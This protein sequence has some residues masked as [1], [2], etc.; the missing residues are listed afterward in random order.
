MQVIA[1]DPADATQL[2][3][4]GDLPDSRAQR[5]TM[6]D[7]QI[8]TFEV[9]DQRLINRIMEVPR[10]RFLPDDLRMLAYSDVDLRLPPGATGEQ[11]RTL[12]T[13]MVL[14]RM[15]QGARLRPT[16][17]V[18]DIACGTGYSTAILARL[19]GEVIALEAGPAT[20]RT[21]Q[22]RLASCGLER[23]RTLDGNLAEGAASDGP[24]DVIL[25]NGAASTNLDG[26]LGQ[27]AEGG[28]LLVIRRAQDDPTGRA[29]KAICYE[30]HG[31][32]IGNRYLFDASAP[33]L[34]A[35]A[36]APTFSF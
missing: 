10:E 26:L 17:R 8:R 12:L 15:I 25:V 30:R 4:G 11:A 34:P 32:D 20:R 18:L 31:T 14:A 6:V 13:P 24:F 35:F 2:E 36:P 21:L 3:G 22:A 16:D 27:L 29:A 5:Q 19:A 33:L 1:P 7:C 23:V 9:T 28:R